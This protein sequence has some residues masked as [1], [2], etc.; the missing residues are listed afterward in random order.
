MSY[1]TKTIL[2][3]ENN[4]SRIKMVIFSSVANLNNLFYHPK[5]SQNQ[6][7]RN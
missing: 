4:D 3:S 5:I 2:S 1:I 7:N 6:M